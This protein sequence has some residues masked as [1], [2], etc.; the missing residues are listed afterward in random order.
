M[1]Y[2]MSLYRANWIQT[3]LSHS[4]Y[5]RARESPHEASRD[6]VPL[7]RT[8]SDGVKGISRVMIVGITDMQPSRCKA[9]KN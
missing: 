3:C 4:H 6:P 2:K 5:D 1:G 8:L 7:T 9:A